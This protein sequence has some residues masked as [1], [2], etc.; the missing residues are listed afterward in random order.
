MKATPQTQMIYLSEKYK[1]PTW[2]I[3]CWSSGVASAPRSSGAMASRSSSLMGFASLGFFKKVGKKETLVL[4]L[5]IGTEVVERLWVCGVVVGLLGKE[6]AVGLVAEEEEEWW[7]W[8]SL[9]SECVEVE[10][11]VVRIDEWEDKKA[12]GIW[13]VGLE[14]WRGHWFTLMNYY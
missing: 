10:W 2:S 14:Q 1:K 11:V 13:W 9:G 4:H 12:I 5:L 8:R 7:Q 3:L 6:R